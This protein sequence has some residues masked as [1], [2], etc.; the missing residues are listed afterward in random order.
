MGTTLAVR[1]P[2][3]RYHA[4]PWDRSVNEGAAEWPPAPWRL[5][6]ALAATWYT[7]WPDLPAP[8]FDGI[9]DALGDPPSY[10]S[11]LAQPA[12]TRHYLP[13]LDHKKGETGSTDLTLDPF[14]SI[15][16]REELLIRW[17][18]D[19]DRDQR[20]VLAKL[21]ELMPYLGRAES[22]CEARLLDSDPVPDESWWRPGADGDQRTRLLAPTLPISRAA[23]EISTVEVRRQRRTLPP[24]TVWVSYAAAKRSKPRRVPEREIACVEAVRFAVTSRVPLKSTYGILLADDAHRVIGNKLATGGFAE[25]RRRALLGTGGAQ[26]GHGHAHWIPVTEDHQRGASV[27]SLVMWVPQR[28]RPDEVAAIVSLPA[29]AGRRGGKGNGDGYEVRGFPQVRLLFQAAGTIEQVAPELCRPARRWRSLTPY[30][31]VRHRKRKSLDEFLTADINTELRYRDLPPA[32]VTPVDPEGRM[33]DRWATEFRRY[34]LA[35]RMDKSRP[36][37]GLRLEFAEE[38][39][40]P[41]L[42]GQLSHFGYGIFVPEPG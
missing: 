9:L 33:P 16:R 42:L 30:L 10:S 35:E 11:P 28:L 6:R 40:G 29:L 24:G 23:L 37:L 31:P 12:H 3:G 27:R 7:R 14:L 34:R 38:V 22:V 13:D 41:L 15:N 1:F 39:A 26:T 25:D 20:A 36:G 8:E 4:N 18:A 19:L 21:A 2:L 32:T 5:L 17:E